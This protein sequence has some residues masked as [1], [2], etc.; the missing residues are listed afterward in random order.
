VLARAAVAG[1]QHYAQ[2]A[3]GRKGDVRGPHGLYEG[4]AGNAAIVEHL[5]GRLSSAGALLV[6]RPWGGL[7]LFFPDPP[8]TIDRGTGV[9]NSFSSV[10]D[11]RD[12]LFIQAC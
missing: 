11:H 4:N 6:G 7:D 8:S 12:G 3:L 5:Q 1:E 9:Q 10:Q 2:Q